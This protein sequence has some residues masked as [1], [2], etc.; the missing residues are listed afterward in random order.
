MLSQDRMGNATPAAAKD[1]FEFRKQ[2]Q[3]LWRKQ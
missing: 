2:I 1:N 3:I